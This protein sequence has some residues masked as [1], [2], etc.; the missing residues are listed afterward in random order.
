[1]GIPSRAVP[2]SCSQC[3]TGPSLP[4]RWKPATLTC[5]HRGK[6]TLNSLKASPTQ[7]LIKVMSS[8]SLAASRCQTRKQGWLRALPQEELVL[9]LG[10]M[11][12]L[13]A[14]DEEGPGV[15]NQGRGQLGRALQGQRP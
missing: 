6:T 14:C 3:L 1:M 5:T 10:R 8:K 7:I 12:A 4:R 2:L 15:A 11:R 13:R 9:R